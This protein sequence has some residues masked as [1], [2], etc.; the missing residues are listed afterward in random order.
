MFI[1]NVLLITIATQKSAL[2]LQ[3]RRLKYEKNQ[4]IKYN[5]Y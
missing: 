5:P 2:F 3:I 4:T 1:N